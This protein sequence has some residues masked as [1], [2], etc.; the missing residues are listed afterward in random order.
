MVQFPPGKKWLHADFTEDIAE[1]LL[2]TSTDTRRLSASSDTSDVDL[3]NAGG[4]P[5]EFRPLKELPV[6]SLPF[7]PTDQV[8][9]LSPL[10]TISRSFYIRLALLTL[11]KLGF[12]RLSSTKLDQ[13][14]E[15][16]TIKKLFIIIYAKRT[17]S[18]V[19]R[20]SSS[21]LCTLPAYGPA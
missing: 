15:N 20:C 7:T 8:L 18:P 1:T 12:S 6:S 10:S 19:G 5:H 9:L 3:S 4:L 21:T 13:L 17:S 11:S 14:H 16:Q 2:K